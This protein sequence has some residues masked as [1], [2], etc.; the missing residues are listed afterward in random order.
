MIDIDFF[1]KVND[2]HGHN[3]GD[4]VIKNI[5]DILQ[6]TANQKD[7]VARIGGEEFCILTSDGNRENCFTRMEMLRKLI[8]TTPVAQ[9][10]DNSQLFVTCSIGCCTSA[11]GSLDAMLKIADDKLY[12][13][14]EGG[15]NRVEC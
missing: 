3:I 14:K 9:L 15:R 1:K 11:E 5:A 13:A 8:E 7:I 6:D 12:K 4:E 10:P 2:T